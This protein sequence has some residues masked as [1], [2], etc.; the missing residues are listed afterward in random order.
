MIK[1]ET[2]VT[3]VFSYII[4]GLLTN[5]SEMPMFLIRDVFSSP[6]SSHN[7]LLKFVIF[8]AITMVINKSSYFLNNTPF[9]FVLCVY[10]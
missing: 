8:Y 2:N 5:P 4:V 3:L 6:V 7:P 1:K 10:C 9:I